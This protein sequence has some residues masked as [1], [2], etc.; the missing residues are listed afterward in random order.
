MPETALKSRHFIRPINTFSTIPKI[1]PC[2]H[3]VSDSSRRRLCDSETT[4]KEGEPQ[5]EENKEPLWKPSGNHVAAASVKSN[6]DSKAAATLRLLVHSGSALTL[7]PREQRGLK[8]LRK[9]LRIL[10]HQ[11]PTQGA[12]F[13]DVADS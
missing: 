7:R 5:K 6:L 1:H 9:D 8:A 3:P 11:L 13:S 4:H 10:S 12:A 2:L